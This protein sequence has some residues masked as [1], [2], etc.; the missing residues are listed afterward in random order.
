MNDFGLLEDGVGE[1]AGSDGH[2]HRKGSAV[3]WTM[4]D[5]VTLAL[6]PQL[7][8]VVEQNLSFRGRAA[9]NLRDLFF[10]EGSRPGFSFL[11]NW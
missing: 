8:A 2:S 4:P 3:D 1:H 6:A 9:K 5:F 7:A 10:S 11:T